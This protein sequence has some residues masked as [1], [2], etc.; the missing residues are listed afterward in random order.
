MVLTLSEMPT[1]SF[2]IRT[3]VAVFHDNNRHTTGASFPK[4][5]CLIKDK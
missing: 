2:K 4:I 1:A 3:Q 5:S